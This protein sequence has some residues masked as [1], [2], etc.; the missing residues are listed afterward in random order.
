M[1]SLRRVVQLRCCL[2]FFYSQVCSFRPVA[3]PGT[4]ME[5][6]VDTTVEAV[7]ETIRSAPPCRVTGQ[8]RPTS[9]STGQSIIQAIGPAWDWEDLSALSP[10]ALVLFPQPRLVIAGGAAS[11]V[12]NRAGGSHQSDDFKPPIR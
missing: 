8:E 12:L 3:C 2:L 4:L 9:T 6:I 11:G 5:T 7:V 1:G 10:T